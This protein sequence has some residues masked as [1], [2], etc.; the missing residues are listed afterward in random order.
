LFVSE[1]GNNKQINE[2]DNS[3]NIALIQRK[4]HQV[5]LEIENP[6]FLKKNYSKA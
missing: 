6:V 3:Q 4:F 5:F 1:L 2:F